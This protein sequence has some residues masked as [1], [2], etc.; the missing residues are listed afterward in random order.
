MSKGDLKTQGGKGNNWEFQFDLLDQIVRLNANVTNLSGVFLTNDQT[1]TG[2]TVTLPQTPT[3]IYGVYKN[4]QKLTLTTDYS[5]VANV[6][7]FVN[8]LAAD[9][10]SVVYKI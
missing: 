6:I 9:L 7:T 1:V 2:S 3:F 10:I 8:V 4:G 5:V